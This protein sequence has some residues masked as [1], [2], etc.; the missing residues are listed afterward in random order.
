MHRFD[1]VCGI[2]LLNP[3][4]LG[5]KLWIFDRLYIFYRTISH[6][7]ELLRN[8][9]FLYNYWQS[10]GGWF[11]LADLFTRR[12]SS[13]WLLIGAWRRIKRIYTGQITIF[14][15]MFDVSNRTQPSYFILQKKHFLRPFS[16]FLVFHAQSTNQRLNLILI[17]LTS[18]FSL[19]IRVK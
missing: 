1:L 18:L 11:G 19:F 15:H 2:L 17:H 16:H 7:D 8:H 5:L 4:G 10:F 6:H 12:F 3:F 14:A 9:G 13:W